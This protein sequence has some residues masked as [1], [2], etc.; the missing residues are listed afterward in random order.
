[1]CEEHRRV[2]TFTHKVTETERERSDNGH[3]YKFHGKTET[4]SIANVW[5][6]KMN[7]IWIESNSK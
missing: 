1:M 4:G 2:N 7:G 3:I 6:E 5:K